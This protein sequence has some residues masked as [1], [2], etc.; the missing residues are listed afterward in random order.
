M[1]SIQIIQKILAKTSGINSR[2]IRNGSVSE[3]EIAKIS[4]AISK[5][6][7]L[8]F[9]I[10]TKCHTIQQIEIEARRLKN[11]DK[12]DLL[13]IDYLQL[14]RNSGKFYNRE[15]EVSDISRT[16]KLLSLELD[17]PIIA[18]CQLNRNANRNEPTLADLRES[19]AIEQDADN[20]IFLYPNSDDENLVTVDLQKQR[21]GNIGKTNLIF[22]KAKS[23]FRNIAR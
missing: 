8:Y 16:L 3:S 17:I 7:E 19:G 15:Q 13:V 6:S 4:E 21:A 23:E 11:Q 5:L 2:K 10:L 9:N 20:V 14:I 18:L 22:Y 1:S 12:L